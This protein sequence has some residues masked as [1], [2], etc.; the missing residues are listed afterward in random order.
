MTVPL[1]EFYQGGVI[2][3]GLIFVEEGARIFGFFEDYTSP[4]VPVEAG[5]YT[6]LLIQT[7]PEGSIV[8][9]RM[10]LRGGAI[11]QAIETDRFDFGQIHRSDDPFDL[12]FTSPTEPPKDDEDSIPMCDRLARITRDISML[13]DDLTA[14]RALLQGD[15]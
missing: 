7:I 14:V 3:D 13:I 8:G 2:V 5:R 12:H 1:P 4:T 9:F 10:R 6:N 11:L 15:D